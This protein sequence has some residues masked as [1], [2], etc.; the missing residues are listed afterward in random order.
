MKI[1]TR[2][3]YLFL[4]VSHGIALWAI[5]M[6]LSLLAVL[7]LLLMHFMFGCLGITLGYHRLLTHRAFEAPRWLERSLAV[8]GLLA[9]QGDPIEWT[10]VHRQHHRFSD[11]EGD[12]HNASRGFWFSHMS[13]IDQHYFPCVTQ[14]R[15]KK[16]SPDLQNDPFYRGIRLCY[17]VIV[18][19][20]ILFCWFL[21][22]WTG[23]LWGVFVRLVF[24]VHMTWFVNSAGH[25]FGF[26]AYDTGDRST[27]CGW[28]ALVSFVEGWH[29]NHHAFPSSARH[30]LR[31]WQLDMTWMVIRLLERA[32]LVSNVKLPSEQQTREGRKPDGWRE[33][34]GLSRPRLPLFASEEQIKLP[35]GKEVRS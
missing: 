9:L 17:P 13:W 6:H 19:A 10:A 18:A 3:H 26:Q 24:T 1:P 27:N 12:P 30:G 15:L 34:L 5:W 25:C 2:P 32:G 11:R 28:T 16:Y 7:A 20:W 23:V 29:N 35:A 33:A 21:A 31:W 22:G 14:D 4:I 8:L